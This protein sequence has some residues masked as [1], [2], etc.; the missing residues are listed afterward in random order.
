MGFRDTGNLAP[1]DARLPSFRLPLQRNQTNRTIHNQQYNNFLS[2]F[3]LPSLPPTL[4]T[5]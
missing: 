4:L 5:C 1:N 3:T 2:T